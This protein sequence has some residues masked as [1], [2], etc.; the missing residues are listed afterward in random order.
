[1][2]PLPGVPVQLELTETGRIAQVEVRELIQAIIAVAVQ[3]STTVVR[4]LEGVRIKEV[5]LEVL[6]EAPIEA[7]SPGVRFIRGHQVNPG[8][9]AIAQGA[10][11][12]P[13]A[14]AIA[15]TDLLRDGVQDTVRA[16]AD[17]RVVRESAVQAVEV[18]GVPEASEVQVE[19]AVLALQE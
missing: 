17:H 8:I 16:Q 1:M 9:Q 19:V 11:R 2:G 5:R 15:P 3:I 6:T 7:R 12:C 18:Q 13:E 10:L 4:L 14:L